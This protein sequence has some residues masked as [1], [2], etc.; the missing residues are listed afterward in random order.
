MKL[1]VTLCFLSAAFASRAQWVEGPAFPSG[2]TDGC[3]SFTIGNRVFCG[4]GLESNRLYEY[5]SY[6][7]TW[8]DLGKAGAGGIRGWAFAFTIGPKA[9]VCGGANGDPSNL[10]KDLWEYNSDSNVWTKKADM[11]KALDGGFAFS[12]GGKGYIGCGFNGT[13]MVSDFYEYDPEKNE[14]RALND[15]PGGMLLF[16]SSFVINEKAYVVGGAGTAETGSLYRYEPSTDTWTS[17]AD[18]PG[19]L[20]QA[21]AAFTLANIGYYGGGMQGYT[22]TFRDIW[23]YDPEKDLW[24]NTGMELPHQYT[25]WITAT[26]SGPSSIGA[27]QWAVFVAGAGFINSQ[28]EFTSKTFIFTPQTA[29][30][31]LPSEEAIEVYPNPVHHSGELTLPSEASYAIHDAIG[32]SV[33]Q[34]VTGSGKITLPSLAQGCYSIVFKFPQ[35]E[36]I[37]RSKFVVQ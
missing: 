20:R 37:V 5:N 7:N 33:L 34:G 6:T 30:V 36:R 21:G 19:E 15:Y 9:Y 16:P 32:R 29:H 3:Y 14:W 24:S 4:G 11:P 35:S 27:P 22:T 10:M 25:A 12:L 2:P 8:L 17:L 1:L 18:F 13:Y 26:G 31:N 23:S 28:L